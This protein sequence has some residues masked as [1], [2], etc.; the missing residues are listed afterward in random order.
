MLVEVGL[1]AGI[2]LSPPLVDG[3]SGLEREVEGGGP[4]GRGGCARAVDL[5]PW[6]GLPLGKGGCE[7]DADGGLP[8]GRGGG[9]LGSGGLPLM[10]YNAALDLDL[11][12]I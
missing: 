7:E 10:V 8:L 4:L 5:A 2:D 9:P 1:A 12:L 3:A 11:G 6:G